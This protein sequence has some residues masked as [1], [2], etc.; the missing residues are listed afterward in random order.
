M[1]PSQAM[2]AIA[3]LTRLSAAYKERDECRVAADTLD[4]ERKK[5]WRKFY[6]SQEK[7]DAI[8][9]EIE[10]EARKWSEEEDCPPAPKKIRF[11]E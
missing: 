11:K 5:A 9:K 10:Q 8:E 7:V 4:R 6:L 2:H 3:R 1:D